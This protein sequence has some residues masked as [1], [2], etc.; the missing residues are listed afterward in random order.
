MR[1]GWPTAAAACL[2]GMS[3]GL[4]LVRTSPSRPAPEGHG[5]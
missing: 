2:V 3:Q 1:W 5:A 4:P